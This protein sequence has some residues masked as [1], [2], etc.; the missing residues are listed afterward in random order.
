MYTKSKRKFQVE[1]TKMF[2]IYEDFA[3]KQNYV[4]FEG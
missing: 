4:C 3:E 1:Y 2:V